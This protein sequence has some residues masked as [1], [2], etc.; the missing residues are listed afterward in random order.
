MEKRISS[1]LYLPS[2]IVFCIGLAVSSCTIKDSNEDETI[3]NSS[4]FLH[5]NNYEEYFNV[6][7]Q[8][9]SFSL[10]ELIEYEESN[11]YVSFGRICD[12]KLR[13]VVPEAFQNVNEVIAFVE[14]NKEFFQLINDDDGEL[15]FEVALSNNPDRYLVNSNRIFAID[16]TV[17]KVFENVTISTELE[18]LNE[19]LTIDDENLSKYIGR[20]EIRFLDRN[21]SIPLKEDSYTK[22]GTYNCDDLIYVVQDSDDERT[23]LWLNWWA[24]YDENYGLYY[25]YSGISIRPYHRVLG[26]WWACSREVV[27]DISY[28]ADL[29]DNPNGSWWRN[30]R[31]YSFTETDSDVG[32]A[33]FEW[34]GFDIS[35]LDYHFGGFDGW[36]KTSTTPLIVLKCFEAVTYPKYICNVCAYIYDPLIGDA[37]G[38]IAPETSFSDL[39][40]DWVCPNCGAEKELFE[41][42]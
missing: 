16:N 5:F 27:C 7:N 13:E 39:P 8:V 40:S 30:V 35:S 14:N 12:G 41:S 18:N 26:I 25:V 24:Q 9:V 3:Y 28:G 23:K 4:D 21:V 37:Q 33:T 32:R 29:R 38:G 2:L 10:E 22:D 11:G 15:T 42:Y 19:L 20:Q 34:A 36:E 31:H 6:R 17:Y 1:G